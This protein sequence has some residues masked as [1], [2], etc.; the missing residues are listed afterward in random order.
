MGVDER[1]EFEIVFGSVPFD[2][3]CELYVTHLNSKEN[4]VVYSTWYYF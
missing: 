4:T 2:A 3:L 1:A